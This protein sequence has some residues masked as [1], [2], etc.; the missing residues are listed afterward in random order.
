MLSALSDAGWPE[1]PTSAWLTALYETVTNPVQLPALRIAETRRYLQAL[2]DRIVPF[3]ASDDDAAATL[4]VAAADWTAINEAIGI[5]TQ[6][7]LYGRS[8]MP[9]PDN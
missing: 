6:R 9:A 2:E 8:L 1:S 5:E 7:D 4:A 3:L